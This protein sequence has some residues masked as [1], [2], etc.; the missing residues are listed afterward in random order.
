[1]PGWE[2][3]IVCEG[4]DVSPCNFPALVRLV[5]AVI[6]DLFLLSTLIAVLVFVYAG[7]KLLTSRGN[8][9]AKEDA[10]HAMMSLLKGYGTILIAWI[11]IYTITNALLQPGYTLLKP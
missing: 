2:K 6:N 4:T 9:K 10:K 5:H 8:V 7:F 1:M 3:L 11:L